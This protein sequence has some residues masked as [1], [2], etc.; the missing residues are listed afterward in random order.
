MIPITGGGAFTRQNIADLNA[1]FAATLPFTPGNIIYL[2]PSSPNLALPP[3]GTI[4]RPFTDLTSAYGA[5]RT[6]KN[7][8]IALV[9][10]GASSGSARLSAGFTWAKNALHLIGVAAPGLSSQ[11]ARIAPTS[12][13]TAFANFFTLSANGCYVQGVQFFQGF[14]TGTT[15]Q[16]CMTV[17]GDYN[18][19]QNCHFAGM[20]DAESANS[21]GSRNLKIGSAG[22]GENLFQDCTIG[23]D[24]IARTAANASIELAGGTPRNVFRRCQTLT[25]PTG[26]GSGALTILG[27]GNACV[28]RVNVFDDCLFLSAIKSGSGTTMTVLGS[29][30]TNAP[31]GLIALH[32]CMS[33]G[34]TK[35]GD[36]NF[37][38]N[39]YIDMAAPSSAA[40]GL[41]VNPA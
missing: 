5:G 21:A 1:N 27:T 13:V 39:A 11:R 9:G 19:F 37:L 30:T 32:K 22:S 23:V 24:T 34:S 31:G 17:T 26:S 20:A 18:V 12:G 2:Y 4:Q 41:A 7:D 16:I 33:I 28:D 25:Y 14:T 8:V 36:A 29:F 3:D 40:G 38:A 15:S 10:N 6:G 35:Y